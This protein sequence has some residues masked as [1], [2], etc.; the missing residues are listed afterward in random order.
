MAE[1]PKIYPKMI[2]PNGP[3]DKGI[4]VKNLDEEKAAM[5]ANFKIPDAP[6]QEEEKKE[7][8]VKE[9]VKKPATSW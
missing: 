5:G 6:K 3:A 1:N 7:P 2:Y 4:K 8:V 9:P